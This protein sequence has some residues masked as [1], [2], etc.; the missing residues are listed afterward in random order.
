MGS[1]S[2]PYSPALKGGRMM[3]DV[4]SPDDL[5]LVP[6]A[7]KM[8][9]GPG[10]VVLGR[11]Q[12]F[13]RGHAALVNAAVERA[14]GMPL[15]IAIGS[16]NQ[17]ESLENPWTWEERTEMIRCWLDSEFPGNDVHIVSIPDINDPPRW[18][19]HASKYHGDS[20]ILLTS[21]KKTQKLYQ[22][23]EWN[24]EFFNLQNRSQFEGWR[25]RETCKMLSTVKE[26]ESV[27][28]ILN[29]SIHESVIEWLLEKDHLSRMPFLGPSVER[30]R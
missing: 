17:P 2:A 24:V 27:K 9:P 16:A 29:E 4:H 23:S 18:V 8:T 3:S 21:D 12:P 20:G 5:Q 1:T 15:T 11:F 14:E 30:V 13:H 10:I 19:E 25:V 26:K 7:P 28:K 22:A 6:E